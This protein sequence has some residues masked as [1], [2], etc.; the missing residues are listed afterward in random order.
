MP[1]KPQN[2]HRRS[3]ASNNK[4]QK[5]KFTCKVGRPSE[6]SRRQKVKALF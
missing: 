1:K 3:R 6:L 2:N 4:I 5:M